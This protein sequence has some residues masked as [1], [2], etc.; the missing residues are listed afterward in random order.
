M[1][2]RLNGFMQFRYV[3][4]QNRSGDQV[5]PRKQFGY[6]MQVSPSQVISQVAVNGTAGTDVDFDNSRAGR[7]Y[8]VN[9]S[10]TL[11]PS[12]HLELDPVESYRR[13]D[14]NDPSPVP[15]L[16]RHF[17]TARFSRSKAIYSFTPKI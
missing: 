1:D 11:H 6:I 14:V 4:D 3:D 13:L 12:D 9:A 8:T 17:L 7:G 16:S 5:F 15:G 2:P 10:A